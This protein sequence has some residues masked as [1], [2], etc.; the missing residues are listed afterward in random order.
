MPDHAVE[1]HDGDR[2]EEG[3]QGQGGT[4]E[5][6]VASHRVQAKRPEPGL[7]SPP[8]VRVA[9]GPIRTDVS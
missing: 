6:T 4:P 3:H 8:F 1:R 9:D 2:Q 7:S 5:Q